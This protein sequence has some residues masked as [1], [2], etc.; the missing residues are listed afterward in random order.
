M[1][2]TNL[3]A[4]TPFC[5]TTAGAFMV[6]PRGTSHTV[7]YAG[8]YVPMEGEAKINLKVRFGSCIYMRRTIDLDFPPETPLHCCLC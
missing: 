6:A 5:L 2:F 3:I 4:A 7:C 1:K 8:D